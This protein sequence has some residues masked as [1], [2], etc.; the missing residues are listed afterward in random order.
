MKP[1]GDQNPLFSSEHVFENSPKLRAVILFFLHE[2]PGKLSRV[3]LGKHL[4]YAD[5]HY[6]QRHAKQITEYPYLHV[7]GSPLPFCF[8]EIIQQ[9]IIHKEIEVVP[10]MVENIQDGKT[11]MTLAGMTFNALKEFPEAVL[12][13][14]EKRGVSA[15]AKQ[16]HGDVSLETRYYPNLYQI[17]T[18]TDLYETI[19]FMQFPDGRRPH[20]SWKAWANQIFRLKW[21]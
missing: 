16:L 6:F 9:M 20:L 18:G 21:Q 3:T 5:G 7:E 19:A 1:S 8:N 11:V 2:L 14:E 15:V 10:R 17:Y 12:S 13:R 4:Y